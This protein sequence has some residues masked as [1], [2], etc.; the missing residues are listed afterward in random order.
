MVLGV[1][2]G[3]AVLGGVLVVVVTAV[4]KAATIAM[5]TLLKASKILLDDVSGRRV[6]AKILAAWIGTRAS[7]TEQIKLM[8][9]K[10]N[11]AAHQ[12]GKTIVGCIVASKAKGPTSHSGRRLAFNESRLIL[13]IGVGVAP[14]ERLTILALAHL[15]FLDSEQ[16]M[17]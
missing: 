3:P 10:C 4:F 16:R 9:P 12:H 13:S 8:V 6:V 14:P 1:L 11:C 15:V 7:E 5:G 17:M 2:V